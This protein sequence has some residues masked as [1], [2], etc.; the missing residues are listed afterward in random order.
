M[1]VYRE[2]RV[3]WKMYHREG[4]TV[5]EALNVVDVGFIYS[6]NYSKISFRLFR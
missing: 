4:E 6:S 2:R 5:T 1:Y 3:S